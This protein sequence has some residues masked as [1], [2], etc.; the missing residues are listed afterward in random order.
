MER[1]FSKY[2]EGSELG[3]RN[4]RCNEGIQK[5]VSL[6]KRFRVLVMLIKAFR[7]FLRRKRL[8]KRAETAF[9]FAVSE[10]T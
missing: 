4:V 8:L 9:S 5:T 2:A 3:T 6:E 10:K 7:P 1:S